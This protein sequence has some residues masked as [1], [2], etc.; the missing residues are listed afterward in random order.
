[1]T[2]PSARAAIKMLF[3]NIGY[4]VYT[5]TVKVVQIET[6]DGHEVDVDSYL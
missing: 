6:V 5:N 3:T 2:H 1:M 4:T